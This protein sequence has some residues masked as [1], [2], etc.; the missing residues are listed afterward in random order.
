MASLGVYDGHQTVWKDAFD[1]SVGSEVFEFT[2]R[3]IGT[4]L[5]QIDDVG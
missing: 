1:G 5:L 4:P 2:H 3:S